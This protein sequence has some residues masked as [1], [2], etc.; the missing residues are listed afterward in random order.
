MPLW[1]SL[2]VPALFILCHSG[3]PGANGKSLSSL[4]FRSELRAGAN[5]V[6]GALGAIGAA[7][8]LFIFP[9]FRDLYGL[10]TTFLIMSAV[11]LFA[12]IVCFVIQW[13]PTRTSIQP[14]NEP[15][16]P[17]FESPQTSYPEAMAPESNRGTK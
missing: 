1:A 14:D 11:P 5:G 16:A 13:D 6:V 9:V 12:S 2:L 17:Q 15:G 4:S 3:G 8:G 7:L 10:Q